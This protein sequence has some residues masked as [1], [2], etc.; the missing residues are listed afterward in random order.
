MSKHVIPHGDAD[1]LDTH[2]ASGVE[3]KMPDPFELWLLAWQSAVSHGMEQF[4]EAIP[5]AAALPDWRRPEAID[6]SALPVLGRVR[7]DLP[8]ML[9]LEQREPTQSQE[10]PVLI[11]A[12]YAVHDASIGDFA[13]SH[14][15]AQILSKEHPVAMTFWKSA[16]AQMRYYGIDAYLSDL[17]V[18][19]DDLGGCASLV[20]LCQGGWLAAVYASRFPNKVRKLVLVGAPID[21]AA[22]ESRI[23]RAL[24]AFTPAVIEQFIEINGG[25]VSARMSF[26]MWV[27]GLAEE[28][29]AATALQA[30][31]DAD[32]MR[33][34]DAWKTRAVDL[35][36]VFFQQTTEW[37]FRENRLARDCFPAL[38][39]LA[40]LSSISSPTFILAAADDEVVALAQ[41][42]AM[43][44]R[45]RVANVSVQVE[46]GRHLSLFMGRRTLAGAW[47]DIAR[48]LKEGSGRPSCRLGSAKAKI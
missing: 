25:M 47:R 15:V 35:P 48:W 4:I 9:L 45:P 2:E 46:S 38:G 31:G 13:D 32:L 26:A 41:A 18:A 43:K 14:S 5:G 39:R 7:T 11:V 8:T 3:R 28:Y 44:S 20:G 30:D 27:D 33:K 16:T 19:I 34:F 22:T 42:T 24:S 36:G 1:K 17:N 12:P 29:N 37:L 40:G 6:L 23:T 10:T 21:L